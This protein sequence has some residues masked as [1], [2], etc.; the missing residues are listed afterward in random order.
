MA[1]KRDKVV[2]L[3]NSL[4]DVERQ[5]IEVV[6]DFVPREARKHLRSARREKLLAIR[7]ILDARI[8]A[9]EEDDKPARPRRQK[10]DVE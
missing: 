10:V 9:L 3:V 7:S 5:L 6:F 4:I 8:K 2:D 1:R